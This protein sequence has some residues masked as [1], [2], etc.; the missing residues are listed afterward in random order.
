MSHSST[1]ILNSRPS[2]V[3]LALLTKT[4]GG[5]SRLATSSIAA[6]TEA[7]LGYLDP[8]SDAR[9]A[10]ALRAGLRRLEVDV[11]DCDGIS[12]CARQAA[13]SAPMPRPA[14]VTTATR[15]SLIEL[16]PARRWCSTLI[17][18]QSATAVSPAVGPPE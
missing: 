16:S 1:D 11:E 13:I 12:E 7:S 14:P 17:S 4:T 2:R 9:P 5:P 6:A 10:E 18:A 3:T 8:R 15:D